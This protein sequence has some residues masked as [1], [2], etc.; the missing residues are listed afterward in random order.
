MQRQQ[1]TQSGRWGNG[2]SSDAAPSQCARR[3][4]W[5]NG[6]VGDSSPRL[7]IRQVDSPVESKQD[8][9][10]KNGAVNEVTL[11]LLLLETRDAT[12]LK[13]KQP[14]NVA[15]SQGLPT[16]LRLQTRIALPVSPEIHMAGVYAA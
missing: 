14:L 6:T 16:K 8:Q 9:R 5:L 11:A 12:S 3:S 15:T 10:W 7:P 4:R 2:T 13:Q 1:Q